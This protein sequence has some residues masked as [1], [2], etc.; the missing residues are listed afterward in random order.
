[1]TW[2]THRCGWAKKRPQ[3]FHHAHC[4][5]STPSGF[6]HKHLCAYRIFFQQ[7]VLMKMSK[8]RTCGIHQVLLLFQ[9]YSAPSGR[10]DTKTSACAAFQALGLLA[11][12]MKMSEK[13]RKDS[14]KLTAIWFCGWVLWPLPDSHNSQFFSRSNEPFKGLVDAKL[15]TYSILEKLNL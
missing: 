1:M 4:I 9:K 7:A 14:T 3:G 8:T 11:D 5:H 15:P 6:S 2:C 13:R 12:A 10:V